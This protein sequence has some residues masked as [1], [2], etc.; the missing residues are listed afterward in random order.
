ML[1]NF[2]EDA[3]EYLR[4]GKQKGNEFERYIAECFV[5]CDFTIIDW[6]T[7]NHDKRRGIK[8]KSNSNPDL[9]VQDNESRQKYAVECKYRKTL[10]GLGSK[11]AELYQIENYK[12]FM[13]R[14]GIQTYILIGVGGKSNSPEDLYLININQLTKNQFE[15]GNGLERYKERPPFIFYVKDKIL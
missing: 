7:D 13:I 12:R 10:E 14:T 1:H 9:I 5:N 6:S 15:H 11:I 2:F 4:G 8:V 3:K